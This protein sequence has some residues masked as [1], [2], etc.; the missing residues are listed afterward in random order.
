MKRAILTL[1]AFAVLATA[2]QTAHANDDGMSTGTAVG[3]GL[4]LGLV[5][6]T[7][8]FVTM[9][10]SDKAKVERQGPWLMTSL[11]GTTAIAVGVGVLAD[12]SIGRDE[13]DLDPGKKYDGVGTQKL[14]GT[15]SVGLGL[16]LVGA[17][18]TSWIRDDGERSVSISAAP[19]NGGMAAGL[20]GSF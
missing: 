16:A 10:H 4:G 17:A 13:Q 15:V 12:A 5:A 11:V 7:P 20:S 14:L 3:L 1:A 19:I 6:S 2:S 8:L 18:A 9:L